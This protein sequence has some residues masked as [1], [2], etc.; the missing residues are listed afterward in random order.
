[1]YYTVSISIAS[2]SLFYRK[3]TCIGICGLFPGFWWWHQETLKKPCIGRH[4]KFRKKSCR[5][6]HGLFSDSLSR[7]PKSEKKPRT[8]IH[9]FFSQISKI[10]GKTMYK[11]TWS[12]LRFWWRSPKITKKPCISI[13][14]LFP[15]L[16]RRHQKILKRSCIGIRL[17]Y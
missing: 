3:K 7:S 11:G 15:D 17:Y 14:G 8:P 13:H 5:E 4:Q 1:M 16:W 10:W 9:G 2:P 12:F 6:V